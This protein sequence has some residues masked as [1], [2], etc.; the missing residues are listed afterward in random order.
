MQK[1]ISG[2]AAGALT[3][4]SVLGIFQDVMGKEGY[5]QWVLT[6]WVSSSITLPLATVGLLLA[7][8]STVQHF[9]ARKSE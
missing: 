6:H 8:F 7:A 1:Y 3:T 9:L 4:S 2:F 5:S